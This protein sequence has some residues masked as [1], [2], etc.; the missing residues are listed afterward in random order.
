MK[1]FEVNLFDIDSLAS[2][3]VNTLELEI[4]ITSDELSDILGEFNKKNEKKIICHFSEDT[5]NECENLCLFEKDYYQ[6]I[7]TINER[8]YIFKVEIQNDFPFNPEEFFSKVLPVL[9][10]KFFC[11]AKL[12]GGPSFIE[13]NKEFG[14]VVFESSGEIIF[15]NEFGERFISPLVNFSKFEKEMIYHQ[16]GDFYFIFF[17]SDLIE[18]NDVFI[19][20]EIDKNLFREASEECLKEISIDSSMLSHEIR[21]AITSLKFGAEILK[22]EGEHVDF[23]KELDE[24]IEKC[25]ETIN[26]FLGFPKSHDDKIEINLPRLV[27][28]VTNFMGPKGEYL[29]MDF[30]D[31][32]TL[33][34]V[35]NRPLLFLS[36]YLLFNDL[37][38]SYEYQTLLEGSIQSSK[39]KF[40]LEWKLKH[41]VISIYGKC[42]D[43]LN[44][45]LKENH[46]KIGFY[47][48]L[49]NINDLNFEISKNSIGVSKI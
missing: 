8:S 32:L 15:Y 39:R 4:L 21:N 44:D 19:I 45:Y 24:S 37:I 5:E 28:R 16:N 41:N 18:N 38:S 11:P 12:K 2:Q 7:I 10:K 33:V 35:K 25:I 13:K 20:Y 1:N 9:S 47:K 23:A 3:L 42:I 30:S 48:S 31:N 36:L 17:L 22:L 26:F 29:K 46:G 27:S 49:F 6:K 34:S 43:F 14:I 40:Y